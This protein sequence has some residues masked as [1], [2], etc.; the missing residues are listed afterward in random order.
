MICRYFESNSKVDELYLAEF[1]M[2]NL[3]NNIIENEE[4]D[5][6]GVQ[7]I[8]KLLAEIKSLEHK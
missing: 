5:V 1:I 3:I 6:D 7:N 4:N 8:L 2:S